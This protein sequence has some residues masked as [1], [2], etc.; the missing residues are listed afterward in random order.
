MSL[1]SL[2][3]VG[4]QLNPFGNKIPEDVLRTIV[5]LKAA[6]IDFSNSG[7]DKTDVEVL[8]ELLKDN[9]T[10]TDLNASSN[11]MGTA[12]AKGFGDMLL[13]NKTIQTLDLSNNGFG[14]LRAKGDQV[15]VTCRVYPGLDCG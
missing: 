11:A 7:M 5:V 4:K 15:T 10:V 12:G 1:L 14:N 3:T 8:V 9:T 2:Y 13:V 6:K